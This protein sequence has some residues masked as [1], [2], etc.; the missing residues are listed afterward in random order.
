[1]IKALSIEIYTLIFRNKSSWVLTDFTLHD[2]HF[3]TQC[4]SQPVAVPRFKSHD[5]VIREVIFTGETEEH[6][7]IE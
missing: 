6:R 5:Y 2:L 1:M 3:E 7:Q 4:N